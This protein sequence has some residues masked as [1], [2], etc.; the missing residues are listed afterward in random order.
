M[1]T[2]T[3][4]DNGGGKSSTADNRLVCRNPHQVKFSTTNLF[5]Y[6]EE[7]M[8]LV[9]REGDVMMVNVRHETNCEI[10]TFEE[11]FEPR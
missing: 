9:F 10:M 7:L 2:D 6:N 3:Q 5:I 1:L 4:D 11:Q 8:C